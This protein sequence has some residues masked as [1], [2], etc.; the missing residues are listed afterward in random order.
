MQIPKQ[1]IRRCSQYVKS[2]CYLK[3]KIT[4]NR[5][6]INSTE[7]SDP[8]TPSAIVHTSTHSGSVNFNLVLNRVNQPPSLRSDSDIEVIPPDENIPKTSNSKKILNPL[9]QSPISSPDYLIPLC[10]V[11]NGFIQFCLLIVE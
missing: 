2:S 11:I 7:K 4:K 3:E 5:S 1:E 8:K 6:S 9:F 10:K